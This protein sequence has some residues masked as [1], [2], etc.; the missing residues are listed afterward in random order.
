MHDL[1]F[2]G[3]DPK[4]KL[5][6]PQEEE[7]KDPKESVIK[8]IVQEI[9]DLSQLE[10]NFAARCIEEQN[11]LDTQKMEFE[12]IVK[13]SGNVFALDLQKIS[14]TAESKKK[15]IKGHF[16]KNKDAL[17]LALP[18]ILA[19]LEETKLKFDF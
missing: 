15:S 3:E 17:K 12:K 9:K 8:K 10:N 16:E 7:I 14:K 11:K 1:V 2:P 19:I 6:D 5:Q 4:E 13:Q 18:S